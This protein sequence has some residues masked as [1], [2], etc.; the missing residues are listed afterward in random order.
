MVAKRKFE[1]IK[2]GMNKVMQS[3]ID[4]NKDSYGKS[5]VDTAIFIMKMLMNKKLT[6]K[7]AWDMGHKEY[8]V[9]SIMSA[10]CCA[11]IIANLSPRGNE[12]KKWCIKDDVV[13]VNWKGKSDE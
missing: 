4:K 13:M 11:L 8:P 1:Y 6:P 10:S 3:W 7:E 5:V 12:F 9:H 2:K